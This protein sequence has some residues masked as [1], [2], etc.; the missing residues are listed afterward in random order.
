MDQAAE[1]LGALSR[2]VWLLGVLCLYTGL[3]QRFMALLFWSL[4][5]HDVQTEEK[6]LSILDFL[7]TSITVL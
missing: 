5:V 3:H 2:S 1:G 4:T 7:I 6:E